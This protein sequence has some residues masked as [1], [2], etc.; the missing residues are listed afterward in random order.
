[1]IVGKAVELAAQLGL[2]GLSIGELARSLSLSKSGLF[3]HFGSK[4]KL[5]VAVVEASAVAFSEDVFVPAIR[6]ARGE[7]RVRAIFER[8]LQRDTDPKHRAGCA[9]VQLAAEHGT[10]PGPVRDAL[11]RSQRDA[12][13]FLAHAARI[14]VAEG[15]FRRDLA[16]DQFAFEFYALMIGFHHYQRLLDASDSEQHLR[17]AFEALLARAR[18]P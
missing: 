18:T 5:Q 6:E 10:K 11:V 16:I 14:A 15:H 17:S 1:M 7:P 12:L 13:D 9:F 4:E 3:A 2:E 8:W